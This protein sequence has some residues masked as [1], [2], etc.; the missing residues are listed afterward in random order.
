MNMRT[1]L[2]IVLTFL[3]G[4]CD[5][6]YDYVELKLSK[7][8]PTTYEFNASLRQT[9]LALRRAYTGVPRINIEFA[10][11][12]QIVWGKD[13][14][15]S[16]QNSNDAYLY[17]FSHDS[18][19]IYY[20]KKRTIPYW[21][22]LWI[23]FEEISPG[24][25]QVKVIAIDPQ[26]GIGVRFPYNVLPISEPGAALTKRVPSSTIEEYRLLLAVGNQL[27]VAHKMSPLVLPETPAP[28]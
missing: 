8:N 16:P 3:V 11:D 22:N 1:R 26:I 17:N 5:T 27:G 6:K 2:V 9:Q 12:S 18:S 4:G 14:L 24:T 21:Y 10:A 20:S 15:R 19:L 28:Q 13:I 23:H 7:K 25:T